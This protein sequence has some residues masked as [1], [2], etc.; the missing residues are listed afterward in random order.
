MGEL[1]LALAFCPKVLVP[2]R[3]VTPGLRRLLQELGVSP[4][5]RRQQPADPSR[6]ALVLAD[7]EVATWARWV[8][9][10]SWRA[11]SM[12]WM[13]SFRAS[14]SQC[15]LTAAAQLPLDAD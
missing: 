9:R 2:D 5:Q 1:P 7:R 8:G 12:R 6:V 14:S 4:A 10:N 11:E 13:H 15:S 3:V